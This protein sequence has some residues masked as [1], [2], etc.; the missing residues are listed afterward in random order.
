MTGLVPVIHVVQHMDRKV[1]PGNSP[2]SRRRSEAIG[3]CPRVRRRVYITSITRVLREYYSD[4]LVTAIPG[5]TE[6]FD[7]ALI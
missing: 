5:R 1:F 2:G 6:G 3:K 7:E 4:T